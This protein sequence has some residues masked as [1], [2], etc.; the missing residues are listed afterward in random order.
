M[1]N[2]IYTNRI[3]DRNELLLMS[4]SKRLPSVYVGWDLFQ[5]IFTSFLYFPMEVV[6]FLLSLKSVLGSWQNLPD[7]KV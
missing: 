1:A 7:Y 5:F 2:L 6:Y 4:M 3:C